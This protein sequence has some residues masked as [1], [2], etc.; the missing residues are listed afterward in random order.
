MLYSLC[1]LSPAPTRQ[2]ALSSPRS[3]GFSDGP[4]PDARPVSSLAGTPALGFVRCASRP[5]GPWLVSGTGT[6][7]WRPSPPWRC[8]HPPGDQA[9]VRTAVFVPGQVPAARTR[10]SLPSTCGD[11]RGSSLVPAMIPQKQL[12]PLRAEEA[13]AA[14]EGSDMPKVP[15]PPPTLSQDSCAEVGGGACDP[16]GHP[17]LYPRDVT[18]LSGATRP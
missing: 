9:S 6:A 1:P 17:S 2:S 12:S 13:A 15:L 4:G 16:W 8:V 11:S 10:S 7:A 5:P 3:P 14:P 18:G